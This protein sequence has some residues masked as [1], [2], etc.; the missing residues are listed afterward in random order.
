VNNKEFLTAEVVSIGDRKAKKPEE[1]AFFL[2]MP[3]FL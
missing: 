3:D 2:Q 1:I